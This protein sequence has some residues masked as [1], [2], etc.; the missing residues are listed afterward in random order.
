MIL[1]LNIWKLTRLLDLSLWSIIFGYA[2]ANW[3]HLH[4]YYIKTVKRLSI[5]CVPYVKQTKLKKWF[6]TSHQKA[7][8][9]TFSAWITPRSERKLSCLF[10]VLF[11]W[12]LK[13]L[14][15]LTKSIIRIFLRVWK[16]IP[17]P[18]FN[19]LFV[20]LPPLYV[21]FDFFNRLLH[22]PWQGFILNR[23]VDEID[24]L[25]KQTKQGKSFNNADYLRHNWK[26][27]K[28]LYTYHHLQF[29]ENP[30]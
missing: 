30:A 11:R 3:V 10:L 19:V 9:A 5:W 7:C 23:T 18:I 4:V 16:E 6:L 2:Y 14:C 25:Q 1:W 20:C 21:Y 26:G 8:S 15:R 12:E 29:L 22:T 28:S 24:E 13:L 27:L 17:Q